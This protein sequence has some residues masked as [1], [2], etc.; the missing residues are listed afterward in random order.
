MPSVGFSAGSS[1]DVGALLRFIVCVLRESGVVTSPDWDFESLDGYSQ[2]ISLEITQRLQVGRGGVLLCRMLSMPGKRRR[3]RRVSRRRTRF[4][5]R[6]C[7]A[8]HCSASLSK[9]PE[10]S[11]LLST[12]CSERKVLPRTMI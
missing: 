6:S 3:T 5:K 7:C 2:D 10:I 1:V 12:P 4:P 9:I 11:L 8:T